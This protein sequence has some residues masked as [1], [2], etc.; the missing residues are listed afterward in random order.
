[1]FGRGT[2][3]LGAGAPQ[4]GVVGFGGKMSGKISFKKMIYSDRSG[5]IISQALFR[6]L[7]AVKSDP[8]AL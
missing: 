2:F 7:V 5:K 6:H 3:T 8:M 1:M 4:N